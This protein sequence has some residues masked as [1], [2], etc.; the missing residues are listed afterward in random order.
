MGKGSGPAGLNQL[1]LLRVAG[2]AAAG[3][4]GAA[5]GAAADGALN[6]ID[7]LRWVAG[8]ALSLGRRRGAPAGGVGGSSAKAVVPI[9]GSSMAAD[10]I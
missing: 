2:G 6:R 1:D 3:G 10:Y 9:G 5:D 7:L 4:M 8:G